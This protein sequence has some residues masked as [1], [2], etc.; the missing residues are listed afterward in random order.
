MIDL[1]KEI[2]DLLGIFKE[3]RIYWQII[4]RNNCGTYTAATIAQ[5]SKRHKYQVVLG[6]FI[7]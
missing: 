2:F 6:L 5:T 4:V 7:A 3:L 1:R